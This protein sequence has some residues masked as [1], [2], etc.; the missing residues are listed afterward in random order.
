MVPECARTALG[1]FV[2]IARDFKWLR[3]L[4]YDLAKIEVASSSLVSRS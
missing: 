1:V 3:H 2:E 4:E